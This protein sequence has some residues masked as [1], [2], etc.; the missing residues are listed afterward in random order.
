MCQMHVLHLRAVF[1]RQRSIDS[2]LLGMK[3]SVRRMPSL[4]T[5]CIKCLRGRYSSCPWKSDLSQARLQLRERHG[6][7]PVVTRVDIGITPLVS[8][9]CLPLCT[10]VTGREMTPPCSQPWN[11]PQRGLGISQR[12][13]DDALPAKPH[14]V[15]SS[16]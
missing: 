1:Y 16:C 12:R 5:Q 11:S 15:G 6:P 4:H 3:P 13:A 9:E 2:A 14:V 7:H 10:C 8:G